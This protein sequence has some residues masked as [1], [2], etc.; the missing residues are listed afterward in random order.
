VADE[1]EPLLG[2]VLV[3]GEGAVDAVV[4][5]SEGR[6]VYQARHGDSRSGWTSALLMEGFVNPPDDRWASLRLESAHGLKSNV[7]KRPTSR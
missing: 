7:L 4:A 2:E 3:E 1:L 5:S 6:A